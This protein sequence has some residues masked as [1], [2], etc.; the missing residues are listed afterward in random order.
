[1]AQ[2]NREQRL[3]KAV[4]H[5]VPIFERAGYAVPVVKV[6]VGFP[7]TGGKGRHLGQCWSSKAA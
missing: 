7:S 4:E 6:S 5:I 3:M 2:V 1:M